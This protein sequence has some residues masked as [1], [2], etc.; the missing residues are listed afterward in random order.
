MG[1]GKRNFGNDWIHIDNEN[2]KH[3]NHHDIFNFPYENIDIIYA[4]HLINYFDREEILILLT[5]WR[6]KL[7]IGGTLRLAVP[8]FEKIIKLYNQGWDL[9][10][11]LGPLFGKMISNNQIIFHK[12]CYDR[13]SLC[14]VLIDAGYSNITE[15][16]HRL[17]D[18][19]KFDDHS[20]AY[21]PHM[22]KENGT[23]M[24]LNLECKT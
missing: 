2:Y 12:T 3:I 15:W 19:G 10:Y 24:S 13:S 4:S 5:Y 9:N 21:L 22:E 23:L 16:D 8:D 1:C 14:K 7:K 20:Q 18:H 11:F 6:K 17:V